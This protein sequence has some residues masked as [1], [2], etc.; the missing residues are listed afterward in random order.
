MRVAQG[1]EAPDPNPEHSNATYFHDEAYFQLDTAK[2]MRGHYNDSDAIAA[3]HLVAFSQLS[4]GTTGWQ[5]AF[6]VMCEWLTQT[7]LLTDENPALSLR[8]MSSTAQL[9]VKATLVSVSCCYVTWRSLILTID[10]G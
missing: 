10:S 1:L 6:L 5:G 9:L 2:Q 8:A 7:S 3:L 4:G